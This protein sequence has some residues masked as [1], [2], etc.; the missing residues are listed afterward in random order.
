[1]WSYSSRCTTRTCYREVVIVQTLC[2]CCL[3]YTITCAPTPVSSYDPF[4]VPC[5][6]ASTLVTTEVSCPPEH[7]GAS[8]CGIIKN[9]Y[10]EVH[11]YGAGAIIVYSCQALAVRACAFRLYPA[12]T[13]RTVH[14]V[15]LVCHVAGYT[16]RVL[17][18][19]NVRQRYNG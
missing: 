2:C 3:A 4:H 11:A 12:A 8:R 7:V 5:W 13:C 10:F 6:R 19:Q 18:L 9:K 14:G 16:P 15:M 17:F 1:M